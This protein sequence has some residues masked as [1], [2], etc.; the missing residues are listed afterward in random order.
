MGE[1]L[2]KQT[3]TALGTQTGEIPITLRIR[4]T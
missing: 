3:V 1:D 2:E 4:L